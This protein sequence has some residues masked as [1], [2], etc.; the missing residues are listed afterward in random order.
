MIGYDTTG[1]RTFKFNDKTLGELCGPMNES[2][3]EIIDKNYDMYGIK[4]CKNLPSTDDVQAGSLSNNFNQFLKS[5]LA[6]LATQAPGVGIPGQV[7]HYIGQMCE[8][9][10]VTPEERDKYQD[11]KLKV[12]QTL[13][14]ICVEH[15]GDKTITKTCMDLVEDGNNDVSSY[16]YMCRILPFIYLGLIAWHIYWIKGA[17]LKFYGKEFLFKKGSTKER[18]TMK[19][20]THLMFLVGTLVVSILF[21]VYASLAHSNYKDPDTGMSASDGIAD[22]YLGADSCLKHTS[23][24]EDVAFVWHTA[25]ETIE[26]EIMKSPDL[27]QMTYITAIICIVFSFVGLLAFSWVSYSVT[28]MSAKSANV[29]A[30]SDD[31]SNLFGIGLS[32]GGNGGAEM[33]EVPDSVAEEKNGQMFSESVDRGQKLMSLSF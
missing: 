25:H 15:V 4:Y 31:T 33:G 21:V 9:L 29:G 14:Q 30:G 13:D 19:I 3:H 1:G 16:I 23:G 6:T 17:G 11:D 10:L 18:S 28:E 27:T 7:N 5:P 26:T 24:A 12:S 32:L 20:I 2:T 22:K 8:T